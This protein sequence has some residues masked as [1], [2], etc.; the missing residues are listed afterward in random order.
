MSSSTVRGSNDQPEM[1]ASDADRERVVEVLGKAFSEGRLSADE[2]TERMEAA[3]AARTMGQ[4][5]PLLA[6]LP[7]AADER[8]PV[9]A[10]GRSAAPRTGDALDA[11]DGGLALTA[12][13]S[14]VKR[15]GRWLVRNGLSVR[16]LFGSVELDLTEAVLER[17]EVVVTANAI[18]G[19]VVLRV[20][21]GVV[22]YDEGTALFGSRKAAMG[23]GTAGPDAAVVRLRGSA[24]FGSVESKRPKRR[25]F[26]R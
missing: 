7:A 10:S 11:A 5:R 20:P 22:V 26:G 25:W 2:H 9:G 12:V 13:F 3:Y 15:N 23:D 19:E 8:H 14:E 24:L 6:D 18:F 16:A 1:R 4:L 17:R 21:D